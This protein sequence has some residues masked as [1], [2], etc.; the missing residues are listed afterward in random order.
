MSPNEA[1]G[2]EKSSK[3]CVLSSKIKVLHISVR[4][5]FGPRF[6]TLLGSVLGAFWHP[7]LLK[8]VLRFLL[9]RSRAAR[10]IYFSALE[11]S[12][13][14]PRGFQE[15]SRLPRQLQELSKRPQDRFWS[16]FGAIWGAIL[17]LFWDHFGT[18]LITGRRHMI[19]RT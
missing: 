5:A 17:K 13:S 3:S 9:E 7:R 11:A 4:I 19:T 10:R 6:G 16:N 18:S 1:L 14:A 12:K 2:I 8:P 15:A